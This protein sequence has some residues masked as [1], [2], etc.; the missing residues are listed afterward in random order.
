MTKAGPFIGVAVALGVVL[1]LVF[2]NTTHAP[3]APIGE[4]PAPEMQA[5][6]MD[7]K[8]CPDGSSVG[9]SGPDCE[10]AACP[11][12]D[13]TSGTMTTFLGGSATSLGITVN[14]KAVVSDSRCAEGVE[15]IWAGTVE[16]R[17]VISSAV[18]HGEHTMTPGTPQRFGD[19]TVTLK[20]V[21]P[22]PQAGETIPESSY[23]FT[24]EITR[25]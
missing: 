1:W 16:V 24:Y 17:T 12:P 18:A 6:N 14:P 21:M 10:F 13:A 20:D 19:F 11:S 9:R 5:C 2:F 3:T 4:E 25:N 15:C 22:Y 23:R 7:A 8:I